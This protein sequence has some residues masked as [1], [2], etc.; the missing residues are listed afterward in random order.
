MP[1]VKNAFS[2]YRIIDACLRSKEHSFPTKSDLREAC[3]ESL[4]GSIDGQHICDSTIE[5]DLFAMRIEYDAPIVFSRKELGYYYSDEA[6]QIEK[7]P[8]SAKDISA[9][10]VA[11]NTLAQFKNLG[12]YQ[13]YGFAID[14]MIERIQNESK[15]NTFNSPDNSIIQFETGYG[16]SG[17]EHISVLIAAIQ[18]K[19]QVWFDYTSFTSNQPKRRKVCPLLIKEYRNRW[20]LIT[21][22]LVKEKIITFGLDRM[23]NIEISKQS[24]QQIFQ[25]SPDTYF[26]HAIGITV[27]SNQP[28]SIVLRVGKIAAKYI[29]SQPLH[30]SQIKL[31]EEGEYILFKLTVFVTEELIREILSYAGEIEVLEPAS[32]RST[33]ID[34]LQSLKK[35]YL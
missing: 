33:L 22:D 16:Q 12:F 32:L 34:R 3:E 4:F 26:K 21:Y 29:D 18:Q 28:E 5:K 6:Y 31:R 13:E 8:L 27:T 17:Q 35:V 20:Y 1:H 25:F 19:M 30:N 15:A 23:K 2:R 14:R 24:V 10:Q 9:L 11:A 7:S